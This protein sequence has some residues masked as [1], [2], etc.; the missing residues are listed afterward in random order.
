LV[1]PEGPESI[2]VA[3]AAVSTV[4]SRVVG[5]PPFARTLKVCGPSSRFV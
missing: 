3:G 1:N 4:K 2:E 5:V